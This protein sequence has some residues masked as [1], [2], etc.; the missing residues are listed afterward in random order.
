MVENSCSVPWGKKVCKRGGL[1]FPCLY[2]KHN[3]PIQKGARIST[4]IAKFIMCKVIL[5]NL[6]FL[7]YN[8]FIIL[9]NMFLFQSTAYEKYTFSAT[10]IVQTLS[11][12]LFALTTVCFLA[13][14]KQSRKLW[15]FWWNGLKICCSCD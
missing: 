10:F 13:F 7:Y 6:Y 1:K 9:K 8:K 5:K 3:V 14:N 2:F 12:A 11:T 15:I 4:V